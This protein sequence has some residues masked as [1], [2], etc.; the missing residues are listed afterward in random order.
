[1]DKRGLFKRYVAFMAYI[2]KGDYWITQLQQFFDYT[3]A[4]LIITT[5]KVW[6]PWMSWEESIVIVIILA[7]VKVLIKILSGWIYRTSGLWKV[8]GEYN[9][10]MEHI[11]PWNV[12][13]S[14]TLKTICGKLGINHYFKEL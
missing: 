8:E 13:V 4:L 14:E 10:K 11:N 12:E 7:L 3:K 6:F 9:A 2:S 5:L 1:M